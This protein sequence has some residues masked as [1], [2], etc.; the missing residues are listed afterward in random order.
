MICIC[1]FKIAPFMEYAVYKNSR[2]ENTPQQQAT[3]SKKRF[4]YYS[5]SKTS[6]I[7]A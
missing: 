3:P 4:F 1:C 2:V 5:I 7:L 6:A